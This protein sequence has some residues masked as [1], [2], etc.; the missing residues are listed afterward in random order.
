MSASTTPAGPSLVILARALIAVVIAAGAWSAGIWLLRL[1]WYAGPSAQRISIRWVPETAANP[2]ERASA[3]DALGLTAGEA[4]GART[5]SYRLT[6]RTPENIGRILSNPSVEDTQW[7]DRTELRVQLNQPGLPEWLR[8]GL[9]TEWASAVALLLLVAG[10][11]PC[12]VQPPADRRRSRRGAA[13][14]A[15]RAPRDPGRHRPCCRANRCRGPRRPPAP[16]H[17]PRFPGFSGGR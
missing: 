10:A 8:E 13:P 15:D 2:R 9:Q 12:V 17:P 4:N 6:V 3:Q 14:A 11:V 7:L 5:W 1:D 16:G